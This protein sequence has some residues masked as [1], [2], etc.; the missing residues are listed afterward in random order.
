MGGRV[1][2]GV[3]VGEGVVEVESGV[4]K[5]GGTAAEVATEMR[6]CDRHFEE[7]LFY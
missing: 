7:L 3:R 1:E 6:C 5:E 4:W 2:R